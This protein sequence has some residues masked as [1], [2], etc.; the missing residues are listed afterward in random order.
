MSMARSASPT[1]LDNR[2]AVHWTGC[3]QDRKYP[4]NLTDDE[5]TS[6]NNTKWGQPQAPEHI[7]S[8]CSGYVSNKLVM[9]PLTNDF[10][11]LKSRLDMMTTYAWTHIAV[12]VEFG[13]QMLSDS[14]VSTAA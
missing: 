4:Y 7:S 9:V 1:F 6:D 13:F 8:G 14:D 10:T 5:P 2:A 11:D 3:T 12:G